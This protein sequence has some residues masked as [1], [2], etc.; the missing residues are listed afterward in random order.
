MEVSFQ[1]NRIIKFTIKCFTSGGSVDEEVLMGLLL[2]KQNIKDVKTM[3]ITFVSNI[4]R[5]TSRE[6]WRS[7]LYYQKNYLQYVYI[8]I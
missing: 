8:P 3:N 6:T 5:H 1:E 2:I 4:H 7:L